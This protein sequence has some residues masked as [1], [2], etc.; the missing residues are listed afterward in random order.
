MLGFIPLRILSYCGAFIVNTS[1]R[2]IKNRHKP[3][4]AGY[5]VVYCHSCISKERI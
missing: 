3:V 4:F 5:T 1:I 2:Y